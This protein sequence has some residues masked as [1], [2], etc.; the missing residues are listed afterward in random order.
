MRR[1]ERLLLRRRFLLPSAAWLVAVLSRNLCV[2]TLFVV[3]VRLLTC[4]TL[5]TEQ[6]TKNGSTTWPP[7]SQSAVVVT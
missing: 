3:Y 4:R 1:R 7:A 2:C 6:K 5:N